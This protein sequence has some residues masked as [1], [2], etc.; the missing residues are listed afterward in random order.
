MSRMTCLRMATDQNGQL[1]GAVTVIERT[2]Y[3]LCG[4]GP[5]EIILDSDEKPVI[6]DD[7][8]LKSRWSLVPPSDDVH[9]IVMLAA[10]ASGVEDITALLLLF[11]PL[12]HGTTVIGRSGLCYKGSCTCRPF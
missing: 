1:G 12:A 7:A 9:E 4:D 3:L 10:L 5:N 6:V 2:M 11:L 8:V